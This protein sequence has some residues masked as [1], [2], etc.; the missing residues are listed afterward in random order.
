MHSALNVFK[1]IPFPMEVK[2]VV[3]RFNLIQPEKQLTV[4]DKIKG[5]YA[6]L[7]QTNIQQCKRI[8][9]N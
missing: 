3:G 7:E 6:Q 4:T 8:K 5:F 9:V 2:G 1:I